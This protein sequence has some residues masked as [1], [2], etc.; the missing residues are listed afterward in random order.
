MK[1]ASGVA[2]EVVTFQNSCMSTV[3][4]SSCLCRHHVSS[5]TLG[6]V[7]GVRGGGAAQGG[8]SRWDWVLTAVPSPSP[9][10]YP[11]ARW[12]APGWGSSHSSGQA[13]ASGCSASAGCRLW[14]GGARRAHAEGSW[15]AGGPPGGGR[16][17][18]EPGFVSFRASSTYPPLSHPHPRLLR[19]PSTSPGSSWLLQAAAGG[20]A[21]TSGLCTGLASMTPS[22]TVGSLAGVGPP[23]GWGPGPTGWGAPVLLQGE[24][25]SSSFPPPS[26]RPCLSSLS[27]LS[28]VPFFSLSLHPRGLVSFFLAL[29]LHLCVIT[30]L[31]VCLCVCVCFSL[32]L[33]HTLTPGY[34]VCSLEHC[35]STDPVSSSF[36]SFKDLFRCHLLSEASLTTLLK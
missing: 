4:R 30:F 9:P 10:A 16:R 7:D 25:L 23:Q 2:S 19:L 26:V 34:T 15:R 29:S 27:S 31:R 8:L 17:G 22:A 28:V 12:S 11:V 14:M 35:P 1:E 36:I 6:A 32:G 20:A 21:H 3:L 33:F 13:G 5:L 24:G 18:S